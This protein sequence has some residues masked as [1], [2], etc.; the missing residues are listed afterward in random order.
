MDSYNF[1]ANLKFVIFFSK[2]RFGKSTFFA[3]NKLEVDV[4]LLLTNITQLIRKIN[5][6]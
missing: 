3:I 1:V 4:T 5:S 6:G 2:F